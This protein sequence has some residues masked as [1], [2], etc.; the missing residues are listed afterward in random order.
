L[1]QSALLTADR[2]S[3]AAA[4]QLSEYLPTS[5]SASHAE[6][7]AVTFEDTLSVWLRAEL[8]VS[9]IHKRTKIRTFFMHHLS[10]K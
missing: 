7:A 10:R 6:A 1:T 2:N 5:V 8:P 4:S 3:D 9:P